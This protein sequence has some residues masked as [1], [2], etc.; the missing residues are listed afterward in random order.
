MT[1]IIFKFVTNISDENNLLDLM[2]FD[3]IILH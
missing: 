1:N 3:F 2:V